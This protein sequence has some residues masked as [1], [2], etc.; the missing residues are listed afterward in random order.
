VKSTIPFPLHLPSPPPTLLTMVRSRRSGK[1]RR[2]EHASLAADSPHEI[3]PPGSPAPGH[4]LLN[5]VPPPPPPTLSPGP[6]PAPALTARAGL[7]AERTLALALV[8]ET[9]E[10]EVLA[11]GVAPATVAADEDPVQGGLAAPPHGALPMRSPTTRLERQV[12][13][14]WRSIGVDRVGAGTRHPCPAGQLCQ[15]WAICAACLEWR[16]TATW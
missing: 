3:P 9:D 5:D 7:L 10:E 13:R 4:E 8:E 15:A 16:P 12:S 14:R 2:G 6:L 11:S 1:R